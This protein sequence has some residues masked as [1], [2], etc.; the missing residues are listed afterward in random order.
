MLLPVPRS[1]PLRASAGDVCYLRDAS[2]HSAKVSLP[3]LGFTL[4]AFLLPPNYRTDYLA[5]PSENKENCAVP[6]EE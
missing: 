3:K 6:V 5:I 1:F 4:C 2:R